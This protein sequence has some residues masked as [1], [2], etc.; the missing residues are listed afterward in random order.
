MSEQQNNAA[1]PSLTEA[2]V[3]QLVG[4]LLER[5]SESERAKTLKH[6]WRSFIDNEFELT[7]L[8]R[9]HLLDIPQREVE[10]IQ[11]ALS[12]AGDGGATIRLRLPVQGENSASTDRSGGELE[13]TPRRSP[14]ALVPK[15]A[16]TIVKCT[17]DAD[18]SHWHCRWVPILG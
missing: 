3:S 2:L 18:C 13:I 11:Q 8:Q 6:D 7:S 1:K 10:M 14:S 17:F 9:K 16:L 5:D 4:E 15:N 12:N